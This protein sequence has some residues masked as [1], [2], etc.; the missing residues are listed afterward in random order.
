[1]SVTI[2]PNRAAVLAV[3]IERYDYGKE[4]DL[5][6]A[7]SEAERFARWAIASGVPPA[8]VTLACSRL[9]EP[10]NSPDGVRPLAPTRDALENALTELAKADGDLLL[11]FWCGHG[12]VN[13][14]GE[15]ALFTSDARVENR[16]NLLVEQMLKF[17]S[18]DRMAGFGRQIFILD[19]C[20][21]FVEDMR[22][23]DRLPRLLLQSGNPCEVPQFA[24]FAAAQGQIAD[25][26]KTRR[27]ATFSTAVL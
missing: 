6:G 1:M 12:V 4:M 24:L 20:A 10:G 9:E 27:Q 26:D 19:A 16:R 2:D 5:A 7:A 25:F 11:I 14:S 13:E 21:N 3:G 23:D 18:S 15:R 22:F 8:Q 17:L